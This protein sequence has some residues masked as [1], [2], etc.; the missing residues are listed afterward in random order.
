[1]KIAMNDDD[2]SDAWGD[3]RE[4]PLH[5]AAEFAAMRKA[6][7][8]AASI[9]DDLVDVVRVGISTDEPSERL[10]PIQSCDQQSPLEATRQ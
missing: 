6:G 3:S 10:H 2:D 4:I 7:T 9:L 1:M 8:L 5:G